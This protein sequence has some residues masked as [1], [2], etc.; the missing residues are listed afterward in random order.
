M[1]KTDPI[2]TLEKRTRDF[3]NQYKEKLP[4]WRDFLLTSV[5]NIDFHKE[6]PS[7]I[8]KK[9]WYFIFSENNMST[10]GSIVGGAEGE[11]TWGADQTNNDDCDNHPSETPI[12]HHYTSLY[13]ATET[14]DGKT[15]LRCLAAAA[16]TA[17]FVE[18]IHDEFKK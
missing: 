18:I 14:A 8:S 5:G 2:S 16:L 4:G 6:F 17:K 11:F 9:I 15:H 1:T 7:E 3:M 12:L 10:L 13:S